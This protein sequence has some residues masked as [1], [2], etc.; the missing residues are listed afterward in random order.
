MSDGGS[1]PHRAAERARRASELIARA[2]GLIPMIDRAGATIER[3]RRL[4][5]DILE[6]LYDARLFRLTIPRSSNGEEVE[7]AT[8]FQVVEALAE[9]DASVAWCVGQ[10]SGVA[11][12]SGFLAAPVRDAIFGERT[13][14]VASG[15][16]NRKATAVVC[17]GGYRV[18]GSWRFA[19]GSTH[20]TWLGGHCT[21]CAPDGTPITAP[22]G[23]P[24]DQITVLF[25]KSSAVVTD[26][27]NVMGLKGTGSNDYAVTDLFVPADHAYTRDSDRDRRE[28]GPLYRFSVFNMFGVSFSGIALGIT[29]RALDDFI[30]L[31]GSKTPHG[32]SAPLRDNGVVQSQVG[33]SEMRLRSARTFVL[34]HFRN[35]YALAEQGTPFTPQMRITNRTV[36]CFAIQQ[37]REVM[38][39]IYHAAGAT[40]IFEDQAF[41]R[42]F[43][44]LNTLTQQGQAAFSNFEGMGQLLLGPT[45]NRQT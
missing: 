18:T 36:T 3:E 11:T 27:W 29:R 35:M 5:Q 23:K 39:F 9:G 33:L 30:A 14:V 19:S 32:G 15:P 42:R 25:P 12:A 24:L 34:D 21:A 2:R 37:A 22:S 7:P 20:A 40:A 13:A 43:R 1:D 8:L 41:E 31:A 26:V 38:Q 16:N 45:S 44:D 17:D 28:Q 4:P 6:A 10:A